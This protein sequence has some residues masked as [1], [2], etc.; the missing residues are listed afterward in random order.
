MH[1]CKNYDS[2]K[3]AQ[4][5]TFCKSAILSPMA[6]SL[7]A[8]DH[9][10]FNQRKSFFC[11]FCHTICKNCSIIFRNIQWVT[12]IR[13]VFG[14]WVTHCMHTY[15]HCMHTCMPYFVCITP[16]SE[17]LEKSCS[18]RNNIKKTCEENI[19][20]SLAYPHDKYSFSLSYSIYLFNNI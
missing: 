18:E 9:C 8:P 20:S 1:L 6:L 15:S 14:I 17:S 12:R 3:V 10:N 2:E 16:F 5:K 4:G 13:L 7:M 11:L 19:I